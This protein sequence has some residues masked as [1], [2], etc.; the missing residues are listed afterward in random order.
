MRNRDVKE[1][2]LALIHRHVAQMSE[3]FATVQVIVTTHD[4]GGSKRLQ[5]AAGNWYA[6]LGALRETT[7]QMDD[8]TAAQ[9]DHPDDEF[10]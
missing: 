6:R 7:R 8:E 4:M 9:G 5:S 3:H 1:R 2:E 10:A